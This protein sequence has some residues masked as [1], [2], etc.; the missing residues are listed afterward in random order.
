MANKHRNDFIRVT[1]GQYKGKRLIDIA[2]VNPKFI[3]EYNEKYPGAAS[4]EL[5]EYCQDEVLLNS[6]LT[7][8]DGGGA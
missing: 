1:E 8:Q 6:I 3:L 4:I 2:I 5:V 7:L